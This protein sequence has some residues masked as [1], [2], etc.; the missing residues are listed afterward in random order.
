MGSFCYLVQREKKGKY[1]RNNEVKK[2]NLKKEEKNEVPYSPT[3]QS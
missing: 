2:N 3:L 1:L